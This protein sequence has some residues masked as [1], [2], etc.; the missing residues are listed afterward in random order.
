MLS[1]ATGYDPRYLTGQVA[2]GVENYYT[3]STKHGEPPGVWQGGGTEA[4]G[5]RGTVSERDMEALYVH[6]VDP[7]SAQFR[8]DRRA[9]DNAPKLGRPPRTYITAQELFE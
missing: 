8:G 2:K 3:K 1:I 7:R 4:L 5:L 6:F 9:W